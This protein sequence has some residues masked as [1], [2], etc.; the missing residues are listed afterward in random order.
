VVSGGGLGL[1][2]F[3]TSSKDTTGVTDVPVTLT[4]PRTPV[5]I[6]GRSNGQAIPQSFTF[7]W[8]SSCSSDNGFL[9]F[10]NGD[11][12][13]ARF[14]MPRADWSAGESASNYPGAG[15]RTRTADGMFA[16]VTAQSLCGNGQLDADV[17]EQCDLGSGNGRTGRCCTSAC[18][19]VPGGTPCR[20]ATDKCDLVE[21][22]P[23]QAPECPPDALKP[24][25]A[26]CRPA[27]DAC[28][29]PE[30]CTGTSRTCPGDTLY[31]SG[32]PCRIAMRS[33]FP[34][35][36]DDLCT[37][38]SP[39]CPTNQYAPAGTVCR[40]AAGPCDAVEVCAG[41]TPHC[42]PNG[43]LPDGDG[44]RVCDAVDNCPAVA[45]PDQRNCDG[46]GGG[47]LCD[48]CPSV[49]PN[50]APTCDPSCSGATTIDGA[51]G[52]LTKC[53]LT[54]KVPRGAV[55]GP[56]SFAITPRPQSRYGIGY[57]AGNLFT[58]ADLCPEG[59]TFASPVTV[60]IG[61]PDAD[62]D[63][64]VDNAPLAEYLTRIWRTDPGT[65]MPVALTGTCQNQPCPP[66]CDTPSFTPTADCCCAPLAS[67]YNKW[68]LLRSQFSEVAGGHDCPP[69]ETG[70]HL[71]IA[72]LATPPGDD[73]L[74]FEGAFVL[75][76][77]TPIA[78][79]DPLAHGI[80]LILDDPSRNVL[81]V[82]LPPGGFSEGQNSGWRV[83][84]NRTKWVYR[85]DGR[86]PPGGIIRATI[87]D[88]SAQDPGKVTFLFEGARGSYAAAKLVGRSIELPAHGQCFRFDFEQGRSCTRDASGA[89]LGCEERSTAVPSV[90][91]TTAPPRRRPR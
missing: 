19:F 88:V 8:F 52:T 87:E 70:A 11:E 68:I 33:I 16:R 44:D 53:Y 25:G 83:D 22:C 72:N 74:R 66:G 12:A 59:V 49:E 89:T 30:A 84:A 34:C 26:V 40:P 60:E 51:G 81:D 14:G 47:D 39:R 48:P 71:E 79:L 69:V 67:T 21:S 13:A 29:A 28:D 41:G 64:I 10:A 77:G 78:D 50:A 35:D 42:P 5:V 91:T 76:A 54:L 2:T 46:A 85:N 75:P 65:G 1:P 4:M 24:A 23:G 86:E 20:P 62:A 6:R 82:V 80:R 55:S 90:T 27:T 56:T 63:N 17:G 18:Q 31:P 36:I 73:T 38:S 3:T 9:G 45:N 61:W 7:T 57:V 58:V 15:G 37:G 43:R 32:I